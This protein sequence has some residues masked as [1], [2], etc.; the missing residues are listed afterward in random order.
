VTDFRR[1]VFDVDNVLA[2]TMT[3]FCRKASSLVGFKI[4]KQRITNH[5]VV[6]SIPLSS[7]AIFRLQEEVWR[8]WKT[9]PTLE[10]HLPNKMCALQK[11]GFEIYIATAIPLRL[12]SYVKQWLTKQ[13]IPYAKFFHI[14]RNYS[15]S[16]IEADALVDDAPEEVRNF[17]RS[18]GQGFLYLQ[19]WNATARIPGAILV[20]S[21]DDVLRN[22]G[23]MKNEGGSYRDVRWLKESE[24]DCLCYTL[25]RDTSLYVASSRY[26]G[27]AKVVAGRIE[28]W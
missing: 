10:T 15:K 6:G 14:Q 9:L 25:T 23:V 16:N 3:S 20:N 5:K 1:I 28:L 13:K 24:H 8:Q 22:Y 21:L 2:D 7:Q 26:F 27:I 4:E 17:M 19:P 18:G 11:I 12:V